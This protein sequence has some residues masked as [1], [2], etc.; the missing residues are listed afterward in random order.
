MLEC[1]KATNSHRWTNINLYQFLLNT[2]ALSCYLQF[3]HIASTYTTVLKQFS[4][5]PQ[6]YNRRYKIRHIGSFKLVTRVTKKNS[7]IRLHTPT[8]N[9]VSYT[10]QSFYDLTPTLLSSRFYLFGPSYNKKKFVFLDKLNQNRLNFG[11]TV[12]KIRRR[13]FLKFKHT[14]VKFFLNLL[15]PMFLKTYQT[16][17]PASQTFRLKLRRATNLKGV[18]PYL[19]LLR[20][21]TS[22]PFT[23]NYVPYLLSQARQY[24]STTRKTFQKSRKQFI[25]KFYFWGRY[26]THKPVL[27]SKG[28]SHYLCFRKRWYRWKCANNYFGSKLKSLSRLTFSKNYW[29]NLKSTFRDAKKSTYTKHFFQTPFKVQYLRRVYPVVHN[30]KASASSKTSH[31]FINT[32]KIIPNSPVWATTTLKPRPILLRSKMSF[33]GLKSSSGLLLKKKITR[34]R[35]RKHS[36]LLNRVRQNY[37]HLTRKWGYSSKGLWHHQLHK[38]KR[39]VTWKYRVFW[40]NQGSNV[41]PCSFFLRPMLQIAFRNNFRSFSYHYLSQFNKEPVFFTHFLNRY[42][43]FQ[44]ESGKESFFSLRSNP[45]TN[46]INFTQNQFLT[47][48]FSTSFVRQSFFFMYLQNLKKP[49]LEDLRK[50]SFFKQNYTF[51]NTTSLKRLILRRVVSDTLHFSQLFNLPRVDN[52]SQNTFDVN[53]PVAHCPRTVQLQTRVTL[54]TYTNARIS[55]IPRIRFKPGYSR[56]WRFFRSDLKHFLSIKTR[57]QYRLTILIQRL[58]VSNK[59]T[60]LWGIQTRVIPFLVQTRLVPDFWSASEFLKS[61]TVYVNGSVCTNNFL[62]LSFSDFVQLIVSIKYYVV[63]KWLTNWTAQNSSRTLRLSRKTSS[64]KNSEFFKGKPKPL[65]NWIF[66]IRYTNYDVPRY[67]EVDFFTLSVFIV[68]YTRFLQNITSSSSHNIQYKVFNMYN[69]KY[70]T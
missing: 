51:V 24:S 7:W 11:S 35:F 38:L 55:R 43:T 53:S 22:Q 14:K 5:T 39:L 16:F 62:I 52:F 28:Y 61:Q 1:Y 42:L 63:T 10:S 34:K 54:P 23:Q 56:Q 50:S 49:L 20:K 25:V 46:F 13:L 60:D 44:V 2:N 33:L 30:S 70:I 40:L 67:A 48:I 26:L 4:F 58:F 65:P 27:G 47:P 66:N 12:G 19:F 37:I 3:E 32:K 64:K 21:V 17:N 59:K 6:Q 69:W 68:Q 45:I 31:L 15:K 41:L 8:K 29:V 57:Y 18:S 9:T 36:I